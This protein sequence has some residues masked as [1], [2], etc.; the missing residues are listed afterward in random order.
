[1]LH[2]MIALA[3]VHALTAEPA[4]VC[5]LAVQ[6]PPKMHTTCTYANFACPNADFAGAMTTSPTQTTAVLL[7]AGR[8][9]WLV[10]LR[11]TQS[12]YHSNE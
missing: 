6:L 8:P 3:S 7:A 12:L 11:N 9:H 2:G 5:R 1:V 10:T 4:D